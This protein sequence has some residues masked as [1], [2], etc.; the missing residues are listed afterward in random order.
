LG[1]HL[2]PVRSAVP[3]PEPITTLFF[4][5]LTSATARATAEFGRS[6]IMSTPST[7]YQRPAIA[8]PTSALFW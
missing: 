3:A 2:A 5:R 8:D 4:S 7:S 1:E 6:T